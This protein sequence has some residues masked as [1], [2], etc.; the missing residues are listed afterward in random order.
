MARQLLAL[1]SGTR[2]MIL[3]PVIRDRKGEHQGVLEE[4]R[5]QGFVRVRVD[6]NVLDI[7]EAIGLDLEKYRKHTIEVVVDRLVDPPR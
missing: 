4:I 2:L 1:P 6:G 5:R 3:A 7:D